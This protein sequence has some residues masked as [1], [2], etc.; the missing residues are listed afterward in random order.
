M[1]RVLLALVIVVWPA[2]LGA[3]VCESPWSLREVNRI[4]SLD[5]DVTLTWIR[6][7]EV[8]PSGEIYVTQGWDSFISVFEADGRPGMR[9]GRAGGG[10]GEFTSAPPQLSWRGDTLVATER[11]LTHY[12]DKKGDEVRRVR[13]RV[14]IPEESSTFHAGT[15]L[16]DGS[17]LGYRYLNQPL[18][19]FYEAEEIPVRRFSAVGGIIDTIASVPLPPPVGDAGFREEFEN[20]MLG[21][22]LGTWVNL[23]WLPAAITRDGSAIIFIGT[24]EAGTF[25]L[26]KVG[27]NGDTLLHRSIPYTPQ[28]VSRAE[29][30]TI[31]DGFGERWAGQGNGADRRRSAARQALSIPESYPPVR[32]IVAGNDGSIWILRESQPMAADTWEIYSEH[33]V[34]EGTVR[35]D[36]GRTGSEPWMPRL[37]ILRATRDRVWGVTAD[38]LDVP[39][40][41]VLD[42][43]R[44]CR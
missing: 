32:Q 23:S 4:G 6:D 25:D 36:E 5:G 44:T 26:L 34:L 18:R 22:P 1:G 10:P 41:H 8:G 35:V 15:P 31:R 14:R 42:V 28:G 24:V 9:I 12:F 11:G 3:Q 37:R 7:L 30:E 29:A 13:F 21:H 38:E 19:L 33:G 39:Y 17:F 16:L 27:I 2:H 40:I 20:H 43:D